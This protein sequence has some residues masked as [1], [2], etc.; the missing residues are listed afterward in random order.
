[1]PKVRRWDRASREADI[2]ADVQFD[3]TLDNRF[4]VDGAQEVRPADVRTD[5][6]LAAVITTREG[7]RDLF[8]AGA[9]AIAEQAQEI[10]RLTSII[11]ELRAEL[12]VVRVQGQSS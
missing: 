8:L 11:E 2:P 12:V 7:F 6:E 4:G 9:D 3:K 5:L 10:S 1:M